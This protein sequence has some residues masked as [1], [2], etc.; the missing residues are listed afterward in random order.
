M[1]I[2]KRTD[3]IKLMKEKLQQRYNF[4]NNIVIH[5]LLLRPGLEVIDDVSLLDNN[6]RIY[7]TQFVLAYFF[8]FS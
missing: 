8:Y 6:D 7:L 2:D 4:T 5:Q 1:R 3:D